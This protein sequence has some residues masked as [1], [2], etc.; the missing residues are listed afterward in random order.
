MINNNFKNK[1]ILI[2]AGPTWVPIDNVRVISNTA[3]GST[4]ILLSRKLKQSGA[5]VTLVLGPVADKDVDDGIK[6]IRFTFFEELK[7]IVTKELK[8]YK[9]DVVIHS[10]AVSDYKPERVYSQKIESGIK[11]LR[12]ILKPTPKIIDLIRRLDSSVFLVG[13]KYEIG[14]TKKELLKRAGNLNKRL[15]PG[16]TVANT[17]K[18]NRYEA[19]IINKQVVFGPFRNKNNMADRLLAIIGEVI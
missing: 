8:K 10:A 12:V 1:R 6:I 16:I 2:T 19:Y 11:S 17:I 14:I 9:Y 13:F 3:T 15:D 5:K 4:G 7:K 18:N